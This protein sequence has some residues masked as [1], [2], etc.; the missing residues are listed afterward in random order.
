MDRTTILM[1]LVVAAVAGTPSSVGA[2]PP[3]DGPAGDQRIVGPDCADRPGAT[4]DHLPDVVA[5]ATVVA[6]TVTDDAVIDGQM[7]PG[8]TVAG[9]TMP[10]QIVDGGCIITYDAPGGCL[11]AVEITGVTV[12]DLTIPASVVPALELPNG[13]VLAEQTIASV[14]I[15][16]G[17]APAVRT[18][19]VCQVEVDGELPTVSRAGVV[20]DEAS[21]PGGARPGSGRPEHCAGDDE[22]V[23]E[24]RVGAVRIEPLVVPDVDV[25]PGRLQSQEL[26][27]GV[28]VFS[29]DGD[30]SFVAPGDVLFGT[31]E[32]TIRADAA[33][34]LGVVAEQIAAVA[35]PGE[36]IVVEGHTDDRGGDEHNADLS[37]RRAQAVA[38]WLVANGGVDRALLV[39]VGR[40]ESSPAHPND[41]DENRQLNRRVVVTVTPS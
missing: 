38:D 10:E 6:D 2:T 1:A 32:A 4:V 40:G 35:A 34:A 33:A 5:A 3:P 13:D 8:V 11:G 17:S 26:D 19:Q 41:T 22:C 9:F 12:P 21:R 27:A 30:A 25:D 24:V 31:D 16:G 23:P 28:D 15:E 18:E 37:Q 14:T 7:V 29:G 36:P 20:R 39:V